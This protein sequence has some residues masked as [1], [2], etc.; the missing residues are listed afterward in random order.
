MLDEPLAILHVHLTT[1][2]TRDLSLLVQE[3]PTLLSQR[4]RQRARELAER[5]RR[6]HGTSASAADA[7][8]GNRLAQRGG[9]GDHGSAAGADGLARQPMQHGITTA[10]F[11]SVSNAAQSFRGVALA[12]PLIKVTTEKLK[13]E[14]PSLNT[15]ATL[16][17]VP[18]FRNALRRFFAASPSASS[19]SSARAFLLTAQESMALAQVAE[20]EGLR[21]SG[22]EFL[23][24]LV[25]GT[26]EMRYEEPA[27][28]LVLSRLCVR[29]LNAARVRGSPPP[30]YE[31][32]RWT[33]KTLS[34]L[35][36][37]AGFHLGN[38]AQLMRINWGANMQPH[39]RSDSFGIMVNYL[40]E[41]LPADVD[42]GRQQAADTARRNL[43]EECGY[44]A[45]A[46]VRNI[47]MSD[48]VAALLSPSCEQL[49]D[50]TGAE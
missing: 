19:D 38:G 42:H 45:G 27:V 17:P 4:R 37:V 48:D 33:S 6:A 40:Y 36:P 13:S 20:N 29:Y 39:G 44:P 5:E 46:F 24:G 47:Q 26:L 22:E 32:E 43:A 49:R 7:R 12:L 21:M 8:S 9:Q 41:P 34:P 1:D 15:A 50:L 10:V 28:E 25:T 2:I 30:A 35:C 3:R 18:N 31:G 14:F 11:Y 23:E 16:S